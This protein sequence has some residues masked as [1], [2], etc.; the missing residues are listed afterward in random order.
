[1]NLYVIGPM[2]D[3]PDLNRAAFDEARAKLVAA[4]YNVRI[5]HDFIPS[6]ARHGQAMRM[7]LHNLL[8]NAE[9]VALLNDWH[10]SRGAM[11]ELKVALACAV[12][13]T[14]V[15]CWVMKAKWGAEEGE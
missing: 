5:P 4:G 7:S 15:N 11:V 12:P 2:A 3:K 6:D 14:F 9:G 8:D 13:V 10:E 1:M